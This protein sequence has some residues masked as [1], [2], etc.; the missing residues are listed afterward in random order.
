MSRSPRW[1]RGVTS[2]KKSIRAAWASCG[3]ACGP[4][5]A[6]GPCHARAHL[7]GELANG[8]ELLGE[9]GSWDVSVRGLEGAQLEELKAWLSS[10]GASVSAIQATG[11][12]LS[13]LYRPG[14]ADAP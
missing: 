8:A 13:D 10:V 12:E 1:S 6:R 9:P 5:R 11:R 14:S 2:V 4:C 7:F 3:T